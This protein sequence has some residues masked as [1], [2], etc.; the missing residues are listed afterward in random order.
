MWAAS[1]AAS[2]QSVRIG[3]GGNDGYGV[4]V[5]RTIRVDDATIR[6]LERHETFAHAI[7]DREVRDFGDSIT[8]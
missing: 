5:I 8:G 2:R 6:A 1:S 7:P 3:L 4:A